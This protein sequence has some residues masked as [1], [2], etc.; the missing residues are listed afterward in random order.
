MIKLWKCFCCDRDPVFYHEP[1][2]KAIEGFFVTKV[3]LIAELK[4]AFSTGFSYIEEYDE[5]N[6]GW[7]SNSD[8]EAND[9]IKTLDFLKD[10]K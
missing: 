6:D 9:Y 10:D 7:R 4:K 5:D 3:E 8:D 2:G 1:T